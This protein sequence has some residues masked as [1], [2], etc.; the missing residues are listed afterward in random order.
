MS[1]KVGHVGVDYGSKL[2]GTTT[3]CG[4][5]SGKLTICQSEKKRDAD[6]FLKMVFEL[7]QPE[8][9]YIDA[10]LSLPGAYFGAGTDYFYR[11]GD[12]EL[13]AMS[14]MF[15][16]GLTARAMRL[17]SQYINNCPVFVETYPG[18]IVKEHLP[19]ARVFYK[20]KKSEI[21]TFLEVLEPAL[22]VELAKT[23][24]NWHQVDGLLAWWAGWR[25]RNGDAHRWYGDEQEGRILV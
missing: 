6:Q 23:P 14:P 20:K 13:R 12:R 11:A 10:P 21:S 3:I 1:E 25:H 8:T 16:G 18:Q 7:W 24:D 5:L 2:A 17:Q 22:P 15:L 4:V 9:V 19:E